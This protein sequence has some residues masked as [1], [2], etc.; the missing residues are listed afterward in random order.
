MEFTADH[1]FIFMIRDTD[2]GA[3]LFMGRVMAP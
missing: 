2:S 3:I 1:P